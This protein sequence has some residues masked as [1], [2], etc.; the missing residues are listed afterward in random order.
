MKHSPFYRDVYYAGKISYYKMREFFRP[1]KWYK[2]K[3]LTRL[4]PPWLVKQG[5]RFLIHPAYSGLLRRATNRKK[6][7]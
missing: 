3:E 1:W 5:H 2:F 4:S 7:K 6:L